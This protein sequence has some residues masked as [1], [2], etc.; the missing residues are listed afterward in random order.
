M[1]V[2]VDNKIPFIKGVLEPFIDVEYYAGSEINEDIVKEADA[3][4]VR[5]RTKCNE[6]LLQGSKLKFIATATIGYD[7]IDTEY[8]K[9]NGIH[10]TNAPGCNAGSVM[11]YIA[12]ALLTYTKELNI[13]IRNKVLGVIGV[14]NVGK[15][16]VR[17][18]ECIGMQVLL[19]DPPRAK[20]EGPCGFISL[21]GLQREADIITCH[22][23]LIHNGE[24]KT[25]HLIDSEFLKKTNKG[26]L[27]INSSRGEVIDTK[28]VKSALISKELMDVI[29]DVWENEP[30]IDMELLNMACFGTSHIAGYSTDGKANATMM[31][32]RALSQFFNL[33]IDDWE[34]DELPVPEK[35]MI[36]FDAANMSLQEILTE[37]V[38][39]TYSIMRDDEI[40]RKA[41]ADFEKHRGNYPLRR[42]FKAYQL[43]ISNL[44]DANRRILMRMG[45]NIS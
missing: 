2:V 28:A 31:S 9:N 32:V 24:Y 14:G 44:S 6:T 3:L 38:L 34:P 20:A 5:T 4:I 1:K 25:H 16:I 42:E 26:T 33:G 7:H 43:S 41:P 23:P 21:K 35:T 30:G 39:P 13:D 36:K 15:C 37:S 17:L 11:Q 18:A 29:L 27:L 45:F 19:N 40:L 12:S 10:W 22:V 8:C